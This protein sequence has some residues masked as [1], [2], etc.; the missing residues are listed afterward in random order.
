MHESPGL[1]WLGGIVIPQ[2][3]SFGV[4]GQSAGLASVHTPGVRMHIWRI[5]V[6]G[7]V[8]SRVEWRALL[9]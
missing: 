9:G 8:S 6:H 7:G 5:R 2:K 4:P 1:C 3:D